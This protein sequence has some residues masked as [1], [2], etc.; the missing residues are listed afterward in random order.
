MIRQVT[1]AAVVMEG[2]GRK[3]RL[4][5]EEVAAGGG[6]KRIGGGRAWGG[7]GEN[8]GAGG[9]GEARWCDESLQRTP[10]EATGGLRKPPR[11]EG[12]Q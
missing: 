12:R 11:G 1:E 3:G 9:F 8:E 4:L 6:A 5:L 2:G 10:S 7:D